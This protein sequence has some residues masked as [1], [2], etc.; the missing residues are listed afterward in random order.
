MKEV[1]RFVKGA[2]AQS[3]NSPSLK[4]EKVYK[5]YIQN[6]NVKLI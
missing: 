3:K 4:E 6:N 5:A 1:F 2:L